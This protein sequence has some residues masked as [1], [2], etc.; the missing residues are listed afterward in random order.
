ME[1]KTLNDFR[2]R[3]NRNN[4]EPFIRNIVLDEL[5]EEAI[6]WAKYHRDGKEKARKKAKPGKPGI[7]LER[8]NEDWIKHF[9][10]ITEDD[11]KVTRDLK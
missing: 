7:W 9:F 6:K 11:L 4:P 8:N 3:D 2:A 5:K 1:L 10:N